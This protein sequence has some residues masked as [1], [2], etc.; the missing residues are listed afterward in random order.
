MGKRGEIAGIE[1]EADL[2]AGTEDG[3]FVVGGGEQW[4]DVAVAR[5]GSLRTRVGAGGAGFLVD[6]VD[7]AGRGS[8]DLVGIAMEVKVGVEERHGSDGVRR[9]LFSSADKN[10]VPVDLEICCD[11]NLLCA[12]RKLAAEVGCHRARASGGETHIVHDALPGSVVAQCFDVGRDRLEFGLGGGVH[13]V[14][15]EVFDL[16]VHQQPKRAS[17]IGVAEIEREGVRLG[18]SGELRQ[19]EIA[20]ETVGT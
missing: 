9:R 12:T 6:I 7:V 8:F 15:G 3:E 5:V 11:A 17:F 2:I 19:L 14:G 1:V 13:A 16:A 4:E 18:E 10:A 20:E